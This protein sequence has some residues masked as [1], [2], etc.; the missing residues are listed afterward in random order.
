M[1]RGHPQIG[2]YPSPLLHSPLLTTPFEGRW[3]AAIIVGG[4]QRA[5]TLL[6]RFG[7]IEGRRR[8]RRYGLHGAAQDQVSP[9][10]SLLQKRSD[11]GTMCRRVF[12]TRLTDLKPEE[13]LE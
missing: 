13:G 1:G 11:Q 12:S 9:I 6:T 2:A 10:F 4:L 8:R 5:A 3:I 7:W